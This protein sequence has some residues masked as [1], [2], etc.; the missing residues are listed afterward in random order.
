MENS[1]IGRVLLVVLVVEKFY[2]GLYIKRR[3]MERYFDC[4]FGLHTRCIDGGLES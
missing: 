2:S 3:G 1:Y 4:V